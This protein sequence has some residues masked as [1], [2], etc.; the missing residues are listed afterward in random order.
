MGKI[1]LLSSALLIASSS[2]LAGPKCESAKLVLM[3][4]KNVFDDAIKTGQTKWNKK[5]SIPAKIK[6]LELFI[7]MDKDPQ[8]EV[9]LKSIQKD[10]E[11][12]KK[13]E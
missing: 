3:E 8:C 2:V 5:I 10:V 7:K 9:V 13:A 1:V 11:A 4:Q 12:I 6:L